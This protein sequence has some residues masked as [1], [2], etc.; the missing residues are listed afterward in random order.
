MKPGDIFRELTNRF[1]RQAGFTPRVVFEGDEIETIRGLVMA[2]L[3]VT[4]ISH[5]MVRSAPYLAAQPVSILPI[6]EPRCRRH[7][8]LAW[9]TTHYLSQAAQQFRAFVIQYFQQLE[10]ERP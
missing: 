10:Q 7:L 9:R 3:G 5:L 4:F 6:A 1:C 8:G 2:G